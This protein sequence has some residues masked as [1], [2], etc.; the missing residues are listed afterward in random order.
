MMQRGLVSKV[1]YLQLSRQANTMKGDLYAVKLSIPR[2]RS[3]IKE[4]KSRK[5]EI[6]FEFQRDAK[7]ELN[8]VQAEMSRL[9]ES[10]SALENK[11]D[12]TLVRSPVKGVVQKLHINTVGGI[13]QPGM[14]IVEIIPLEDKLL[15]ETK[16][17]P[18]DIAYLYSGQKAVIKFT[19]YDFSIYGGLNGVLT[20]ISADTIVDDDGETY[21]LVRIA[22]DKNYLEKNGKK[23]SILIGM[24]ASVDIITGKKSVLDYILKP[25][26]KAKH[27][28]LS[29]R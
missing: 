18:S 21:Y 16:I 24:V 20:H 12:R 29:E 10:G 26:L 7:E 11:V 25:I 4:A 8:S 2:L 14:D 23:N 22:T 1:E 13:V 17:K 15:I 6:I 5:D 27:G 28:A 19:A 3:I 9:Q